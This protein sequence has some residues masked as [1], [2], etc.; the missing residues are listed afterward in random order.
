MSAQN[1]AAGARAAKIVL[2]AVPPT[3]LP[4]PALEARLD[5][6]LHRRLTLVFAGAGFGKSTLV[7]AWASRVHAAWY[8]LAADDSAPLAL[9][10]GLVAALR[11][12]LPAY[13]RS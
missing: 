2:P 8:A 13:R 1:P 10:E 3:A 12:R 9:A 4:R 7:A 5:E 6:A 11:L